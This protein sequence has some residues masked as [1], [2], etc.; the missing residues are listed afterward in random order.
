M[1]DLSAY[2]QQ[3]GDLGKAAVNAENE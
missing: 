3:V 1:S 2:R